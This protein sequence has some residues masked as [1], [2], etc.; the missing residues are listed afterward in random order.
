VGAIDAKPTDQRS[1]PLLVNEGFPESYVPSGNSSS[2]HLLFYRE[3]TILAQPFNPNKLELS[4]D[5]APVAEQVGNYQGAIGFFSAS[6]NGVLVYVG[7]NGG[8]G[9]TQLTW[10]DR[11]GKNL[12]IVGGPGISPL[13][14]YLV[15]ASKPL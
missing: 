6:T 3:G 15:M 12:G 13:S 11:A 7:G 5:P 14:L 2:G 10:F 1:K 9:N 8:A 4:G